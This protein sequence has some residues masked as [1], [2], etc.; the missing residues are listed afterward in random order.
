[1]Q[2]TGG[3]AHNWRDVVLARHE[4]GKGQPSRNRK[5]GDSSQGLTGF[6][7]QQY[8]L[9]AILF[10]LRVSDI[11]CP[12]YPLPLYPSHHSYRLKSVKSPVSDRRNGPSIPQLDR[13]QRQHIPARQAPQNRPHHSLLPDPRCKS[14]FSP[15]CCGAPTSA[16][17][18]NP[19]RQAT[20]PVRQGNGRESP[21]LQDRCIRPGWGPLHSERDEHL[22][23]GRLG[24]GEKEVPGCFICSLYLSSYIPLEDPTTRRSRPPHC[25]SHQGAPRTDA[26]GHPHGC[27]RKPYNSSAGSR[28]QAVGAQ[29]QRHGSPSPCLCFLGL[30]TDCPA[31]EHEM[32]RNVDC[33]NMRRVVFV[34]SRACKW[35]FTAWFRY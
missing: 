2:G 12:V 13:Q 10:S 29:S 23:F 1:M 26:F 3:W 14:P 30:L 4:S 25:P 28:L 20:V 24:R 16:R 33:W 22:R 7:R 34:M 32:R 18:R 21:S 6:Q 17:A 35:S 8:L 19:P 31:L 15:R 11:S 9:S 5:A 27:T